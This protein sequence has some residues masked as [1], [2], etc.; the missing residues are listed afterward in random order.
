MRAGLLDKLITIREPVSTARSTDG[1]PIYTQS[2]LLKDVWAMVDV[3]TGRED[4]RD[5]ARWDVQEVDFIMRWTTHTIA[6]DMVVR[7]NGSDYDIKAVINVAEADRELH[8]ITRK[9]S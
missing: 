2:T 5:R 7:Y 6:P 3:R 9:R 8:L 1:A 4:Y